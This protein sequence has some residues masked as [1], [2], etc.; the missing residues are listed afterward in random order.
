MW[1]EGVALEDHGD[2][3]VLRGDVVDDL[4]ADQQGAVGDLLEPSNHA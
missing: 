2:V 4:V 1:V 3:T